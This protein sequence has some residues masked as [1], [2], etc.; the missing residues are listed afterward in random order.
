MTGKMRTA[1]VLL[2]SLWASCAQAALVVSTSATS[3]V[4]CSG[5]VCT[6]TAANAVLNAHDLMVS[7]AHGDTTLLSGSMAQD[8]EFD[9]P[10]HW[11]SAHRLALDSYR[12]IAFTQPVISEGAGG[13]TITTNDGGTG[14]DFIFSGKGR[15]AFWNLSSSLIINGVSY[16]LV[17]NIATLA[18]DIA[19]VPSGNY[20][21]A[22][23]YDA[24]A[25]GTYDHTPIPT[26]LSGVFEGL[27]N[28]I[29]HLSIDSGHGL[30]FGITGAGRDVTL[31]GEVLKLPSGGSINVG[32]FASANGGIISNVNLVGGLVSVMGPA[33]IGALAGYSN[34][35]IERSHASMRV[36][37]RAF[38]YVGGLV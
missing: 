6:V 16:T 9:I 25:D 4:S 27:G 15:V 20:A 13:L 23:D 24:S 36:S 31:V 35:T 33:T 10:V 21:L 18:S 19:S 30:F 5:G 1:A 7:L 32:G 34:A 2:A 17:G 38:C 14:G 12:T 11:T 37:C 8:I 22:S 3:N 28:S 26:V 29:L